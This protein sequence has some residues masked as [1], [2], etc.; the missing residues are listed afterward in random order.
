MRDEF[1]TQLFMYF[2]IG[3]V[4]F[5][6]TVFIVRWIFNIPSILRYHRAQIKLLEQMAKNQG[7]DGAK[8]QKIITESE[9]WEEA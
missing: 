7:V 9:I 1:Y 3:F 2:A 6:I 4:C 5:L 8:V